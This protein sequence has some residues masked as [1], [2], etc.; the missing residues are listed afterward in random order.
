MVD[1]KVEMVF[2][3]THPLLNIPLIYISAVAALLKVN[4]HVA[5]TGEENYKF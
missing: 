3:A 1:Q 5:R 2:K 4:V